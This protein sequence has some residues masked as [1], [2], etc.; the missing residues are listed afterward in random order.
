MAAYRAFTPKAS[1]EVDYLV[2]C[3][4]DD[5]VVRCPADDYAV[6]IPPDDL[7]CLV[8]PVAA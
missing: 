6:V 1:T 4:A 3:P 2:L 7:S 8:L 5:Y